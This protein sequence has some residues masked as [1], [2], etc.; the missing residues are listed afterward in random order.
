MNLKEIR[1]L[2]ASKTDACIKK[3]R[4]F[5]GA[6][7]AEQDFDAMSFVAR[8]LEQDRAALIDALERVLKTQHYEMSYEYVCRHARETLATVKEQQ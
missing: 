3:H 2:P 4:P 6:A 5:A 8:R 7:S 1:E